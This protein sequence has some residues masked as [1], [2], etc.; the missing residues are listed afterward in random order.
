MREAP[1]KGKVANAAM[2]FWKQRASWLA[3]AVW[4]CF[5]TPA[6]AGAADEAMGAVSKLTVQALP[7]AAIM[8]TAPGGSRIVAI[9]YSALGQCGGSGAP[10]E[11]TGVVVVYGVPEGVDAHRLATESARARAEYRPEALWGV[12]AV[13]PGPAS[14]SGV[15]WLRDR[16]AVLTGQNVELSVSILPVAGAS[17]R[18]AWALLHLHAPHLGIA[19]V[20]PVPL[21]SVSPWPDEHDVLILQAD[22]IAGRVDSRALSILDP[23]VA[24]L[25]DDHR[26]LRRHARLGEL[27]DRLYDLWIDVYTVDG[28]TPFTLWADPHGVFLPLHGHHAWTR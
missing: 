3:V 18:S 12:S 25:I 22:P 28:A 2:R 6:S 7:H 17:S 26:L 14:A 27:V 24:V 4:A 16:K 5:F 1:D 23:G 9:P 19:V 10:G 15:N 13:L 21:Q 20:Y 11:R 8:L